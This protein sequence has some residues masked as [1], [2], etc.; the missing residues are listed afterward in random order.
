MTENLVEGLDREIKRNRELLDEYKSIPSG[1][2]AA[3]F[4]GRDVDAAIH[5]L[6]SGD[7]VEMMKI[8]NTL[9]SHE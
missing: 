7:V 9:K 6:G 4:I 8:Y 3:T 1:V 5:A 2:F